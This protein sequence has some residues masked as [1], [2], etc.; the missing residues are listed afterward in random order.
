[1]R[2]NR[3]SRRESAGHMGRAAHLLAA[4]GP[5]FRV[6]LACLAG[7]AAFAAPAQAA[8]PRSADPSLARALARALTVPHVAASRTG[9]AAID[10]ETGAAVYTQNGSLSL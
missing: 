6:A 4:P 1:M 8:A 9:A 2:V 10:L 3:L 7:F 5:S